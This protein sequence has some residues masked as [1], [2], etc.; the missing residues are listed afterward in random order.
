MARNFRNAAIPRTQ[1]Q[2]DAW[3]EALDNFVC[4]NDQS[5]IHN[6]RQADIVADELGKWIKRQLEQR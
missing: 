4:H 2:A 5:R 1:E 6:A 3:A